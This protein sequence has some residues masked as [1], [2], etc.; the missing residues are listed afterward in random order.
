MPSSLPLIS[1]IRAPHHCNMQLRFRYRIA[2]WESDRR[3][4]AEQRSHF[5]ERSICIIQRPL[6]LHAR[7]CRGLF[8]GYTIVDPSDT[9]HKQVLL[10]SLIVLTSCAN[11]RQRPYLNPST[12][13]KASEAG[14][15]LYRV[16][17][18][19]LLR[20]CALLAV[21]GQGA[22]AMISLSVGGLCSSAPRQS[23]ARPFRSG[24]SFS[25]CKSV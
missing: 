20:A 7:C 5:C 18:T 14:K 19:F 8:L 1:V 4:S 15:L 23:R 21:R 12:F 25:H 24:H 3:D 2:C 16:R 6:D 13:A 9:Q 22:C 17:P 11:S 10:A